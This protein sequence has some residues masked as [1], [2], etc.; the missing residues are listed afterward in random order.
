MH[1]CN[2]NTLSSMSKEFID[3]TRA[4]NALKIISGIKV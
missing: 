1:V 2:A 3:T 4:K